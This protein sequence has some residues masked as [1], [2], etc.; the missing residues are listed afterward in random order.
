MSLFTAAEIQAISKH[1]RPQGPAAAP[2]QRRK[3]SVIPKFA[4]PGLAIMLVCTLIFA[5]VPFGQDSA[6]AKSGSDSGYHFYNL[7]LQQNNDPADDFNFGYDR[8]AAA[9]AS[10]NN[11]THWLDADFKSS[12][13]EDPA[14]AAATMAYADS[15]LGTR[16]MGVFYDSADADW[17][18]AINRARDYFIKH[19]QRWHKRVANFVKFLDEHATASLAAADS[20]T[21]QMYMNPYTTSGKPDVIAMTTSQQ[22]GH[23]LS[24]KIVIK[25]NNFTL[26]YRCECGYQPTGVVKTMGITPQSPTPNRPGKPGKPDQPN[27]QPN[28][29]KDKSKDPVN[30]NNANTGGGKNQDS[31]GS[32]N[33]Q[34]A[35][36]PQQNNSGGSSSSGS[37]S[38]GNLPTNHGTTSGGS[39][40][41]GQTSD[42]AIAEPD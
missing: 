29:S 12:L 10:D 2:K 39:S 38:S 16:F 8:Y 1:K 25:G 31:D 6:A 26:N 37:G 19:P 30:Q 23:Y 7:D 27:P 14:L 28:P 5:F 41:G 11:I 33:Y 21:D 36:P 40:V 13:E 22:T 3:K 4:I 34:P 9:Q 24:Y 18:L 32:G 35:K 20:Y 17:S 42:G 15:V